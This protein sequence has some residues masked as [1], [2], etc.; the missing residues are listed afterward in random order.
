MTSTAVDLSGRLSPQKRAYFDAIRS[1]WERKAFKLEDFATRGPDGRF[2]WY[3]EPLNSKV[4]APKD[5]L[6][7]TIGYRP[8]LPACMFHASTARIKVYSGGARAGKSLAGAMEILPIL[9]TP[10]TNTWLVGP[11]YDQCQKEFDYLVTNSI[12]HPELGPLCAPFLKRYTNHPQRGD[13]EIRLSWGDAGESWVKVKTAQREQSLLSEELDCVLVVEAAEVKERVWSR[14]LSMRLMT[15]KGIAIFPSSPKG[16][17]W[18]S[19]LYQ[20]GLSGKA[21][22]FAINADSRMNP[23]LDPAEVEFMA[24]NL[25]DEDWREQIEGRPTPRFGSVYRGFSYDTHVASWNPEWPK[26]TWKRG[27]A[28]DFGYK[29]P[30]CILWAAEDED[31]RVYIYREFYEKGRLPSDMVQ[32]IANVEGWRTEIGSTKKL[33]L[34]GPPKFE[35]MNHVTIA[36]WDAAGR[37]E[38]IAAGIATMKADKDIER[39]VRAVAQAMRVQN[40]RR[41][42]LYIHPNCVNLI[43]ELQ[44]YEWDERG[45]KP[46]AGSDHALDALRYW[47][48]TRRT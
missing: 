14:F 21:G 34:R 18:L 5:R 39:G 46:K 16:L 4:L 3:P 17:G 48:A 37:A 31:R 38:L 23:T 32:F 6:Y 1:A 15:R 9:M 30:C 41:P 12:H 43:R 44:A 8:S 35:R 25:T 42:R 36:D 11:E 29:D 2:L 19:D 13:M 20:R 24:E 10:G 47:I 40:D 33:M 7:R 26:P 28:I 27:R 45:E 22:Y